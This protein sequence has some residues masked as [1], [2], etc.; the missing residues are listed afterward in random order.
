[1]LEYRRGMI[2]PSTTS[3]LW[4]SPSI[5]KTITSNAFFGGG[6]VSLTGQVKVWLGSF[7]A[8][9]VKVWLGSWVTKPVKYWNG[10]SWIETDY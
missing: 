2:A 4:T 9:P 6:A 5:A 1:M 8:K 3:P 10:T 7:I